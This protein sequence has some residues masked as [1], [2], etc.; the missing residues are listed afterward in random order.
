MRPL[1]HEIDNVYIC[2]DGKKFLDEKKAKAYQSRLEFEEQKKMIRMEIGSLKSTI[3]KL[4]NKLKSDKYKW[5]KYVLC[6][7][8][9]NA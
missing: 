6:K 9:G 5:R 1:Q 3:K 8:G 4:E 7:S 2:G